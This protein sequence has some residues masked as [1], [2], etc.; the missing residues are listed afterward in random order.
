M[1]S[2]KIEKRQDASTRKVFTAVKRAF[3]DVPDEIGE[4]VYRYNPVAVRIRVVSNSL[5]GLDDTQRDDAVMGA[6]KELPKEVRDNITM[7]LAYTPDELEE[8]D[9]MMKEFDDP[10]RSRL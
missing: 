4:V 8:W 6:L 3:P 5:M 1:V 7:I 9:Y 2:I 10:S